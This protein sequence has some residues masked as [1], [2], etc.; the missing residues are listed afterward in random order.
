[1][2][3]GLRTTW[4]PAEARLPETHLLVTSARAP[5]R[6]AAKVKPY[7]CQWCRAVNR[8]GEPG[9]WLAAKWLAGTSPGTILNSG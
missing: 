6:R 5:D 3:M 9:L 8:G 7:L 4:T 1:M 2:S